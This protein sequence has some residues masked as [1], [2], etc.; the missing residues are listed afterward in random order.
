M[1]RKQLQIVR[2][3]L[4][5]FCAVIFATGAITANAAPLASGTALKITPG[6]GSGPNTPCTSGSCI[7][8]DLI[9]GVFF[10]W[11]DIA[12]GKDGGFVVGK[13]QA[14]GG[15][16]LIVGA[17]NPNPTAPGELTAASGLFF[18]ASSPDLYAT[19]YTLPDGGSVNVFD[20]AGCT[21]AACI[22]KTALKT[23]NVAW[24]GIS[25]PMG[26][27]AG[28]PPPTACTADQLAG[29]F[30]NNYTIDLVG[31]TWSMDYA[32]VVPSGPVQGVPFTVI[33]RGTVGTCPIV[34][35]ALQSPN[36]Q[37]IVV[38]GSQLTGATGVTINGVK[39]S[40]F[41]VISDDILWA[42]IPAGVP[43]PWKPGT[44][45]VSNASCAGSFPK[46]CVP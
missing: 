40:V 23:L 37:L 7:G 34:D 8:W 13:S 44:V 26:S 19:L 3:V 1:T 10:S 15:Q 12:P 24:N 32:Q 6:V 45:Q 39:A 30:V 46:P 20:D 31:K 14:S 16:E 18:N 5:I 21:K 42:F 43:L 28:C 38:F 22:G 11:R 35:Y 41:G 17:L 25:I 4:F 33:F 9:P 36:T 29:I 27:A 2:K